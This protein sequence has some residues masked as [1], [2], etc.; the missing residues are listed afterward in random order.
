ME[1]PFLDKFGPT[2][3]NCQFKLKFGKYNHFHNILRLFDVLPNFLFTTSETMRSYY[4]ETWY[5]LSHEL[6]N[7]SRLKD[8]SLLPSLPAKMKNLLII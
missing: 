7:D 4:L 6:P 5:E 8:N 3:E 1:T 2:N